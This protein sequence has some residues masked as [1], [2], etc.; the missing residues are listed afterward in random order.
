V[1]LKRLLLAIMIIGSLANF[2]QKGFT[3]VSEDRWY[4]VLPTAAGALYQFE[5]VYCSSRA[6]A[7]DEAAIWRAS[8]YSSAHALPQ[9]A[10]DA[11]RAAGVIDPFRVVKRTLEL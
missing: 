9:K 4:V 10:V 5:L 6:A 1:K 11:Q 8:G 7:Q 2:P 3:Q